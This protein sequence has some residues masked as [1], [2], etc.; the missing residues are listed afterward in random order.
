MK[1]YADISKKARQISSSKECCDHCYY[2]GS[3]NSV[4]GCNCPFSDAY[5]E[6]MHMNPCY[7]G[8]LIHLAKKETLAEMSSEEM[9]EPG[10]SGE[11]L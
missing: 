1:T 11:M 7:E 8:A 2:C 5:M 4:F 3:K 9:A 6:D 10:Q